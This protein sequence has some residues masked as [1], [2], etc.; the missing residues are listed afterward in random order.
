[1]NEINCPHCKKAFKVD[2]AGYADI[3]KQVKNHEFEDELKTRLALAE[4]DKLNAVKLAEATTRNTFQEHL[5]KKELEIKELKSKSELTL[6]EKIGVKENEIIQ[7]KAKIDNVEG[8][9]KN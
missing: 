5:A 8:Y 9:S 6:A 2:E 1:M 7:L 4:N 3:L